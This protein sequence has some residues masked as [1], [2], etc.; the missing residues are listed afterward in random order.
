MASNYELNVLLFSVI[1]A[2]E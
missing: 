2:S 1:K